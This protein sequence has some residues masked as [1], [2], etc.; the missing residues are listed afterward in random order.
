MA[1]NFRQLD[2]T[3]LRFPNN[4]DYYRYIQ[5]NGITDQD[6]AYDFGKAIQGDQYAQDPTLSTGQYSAYIPAMTLPEVSVTAPAPQAKYDPE[7]GQMYYGSKSPGQLAIE[8]YN[9]EQKK[10]AAAENVGTWK[11]STPSPNTNGGKEPLITIKVPEVALNIG[12]KMW[13]DL[14]FNWDQDGDGVGDRIEAM[15]MGGYQE[16]F[17]P[18][19]DAI[20]TGIA[21]ALPWGS[22]GQL[23]KTPA[24]LSRTLA[25]ISNYAGK[26]AKPVLGYLDDAGRWISTHT[27]Q[28]LQTAGQMAGN[29][30]QRMYT[31]ALLT[32]VPEVMKADNVTAGEQQ[33]GGIDW[34]RALTLAEMASV[35]RIPFVGKKFFKQPFRWVSNA[36][37]KSLWYNTANAA[38]YGSLGHW[39]Y[40]ALGW[41]NPGGTDMSNS[42]E[43]DAILNSAAQV[44]TDVYDQAN[45]DSLLNAEVVDSLLN[46]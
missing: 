32:Q 7:T 37:G 23:V 8:Q 18:G 39:G 45:I 42:A 22:V 1:V 40:D 30:Y 34:N 35:G 14:T 21:L 5:E 29:A 41:S 16:Y 13:E 26:V 3:I 38:A 20:G 6:V 31:T 24:W 46:E 43:V 4:E 12:K 27:P 15:N 10:K 25:P 19:F 44:S 28:A 36:P 11:S 9:A 2:G 33:S 17:R